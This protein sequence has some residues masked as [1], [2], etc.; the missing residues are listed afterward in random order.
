MVRGAQFEWHGREYDFQEK[1]ADWYWALGII[2]TAAIVAAVL[3][4]NVLLALV[5][6]A[7]TLA[8]ALASAK[9]PK[10]HRFALTEEGLLID[11]DLFPYDTMISFSAIEY[12]DT[13]LPPSLSI[14]TKSILSPHLLVPLND[15]DT[16][17][18]YEFI[19]YHVDHE[20]HEHSFTDRL[21]ELFRV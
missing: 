15:V 21:I 5:I 16:D 11:R 20:P 1:S 6:A 10:V 18:V 9:H 13:S 3:F 19:A 8:L 12:L 4:G 14:K 17:A 2:A 7:G